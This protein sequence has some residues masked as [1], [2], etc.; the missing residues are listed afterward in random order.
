LVFGL[1]TRSWFLLLLTVVLVAGA[2][3]WL[4]LVVDAWRLARPGLL[5]DAGRGALAAATLCAVLLSSGTMLV[6]ARQ[7]MAG[8][9]LISDV[10]GGNETSAAVDGRYNVLL[11]CGDAGSDRIVVRPDSLTLASIDADTGRTVLFSLPR[12]MQNIPFPDDSPMHQ[13]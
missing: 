4:V 8:H 11:L 12:N 13:A 7:V 9:D 2:V 1:V 6:G 3:G 5:S 10:F